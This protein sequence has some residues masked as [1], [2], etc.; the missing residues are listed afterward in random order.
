[1][2]H[3][4]AVRD[5]NQQQKKVLNEMADPPLFAWGLSSV[6]AGSSGSQV[7]AALF[8]KRISSPDE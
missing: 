3:G 6:A 4:H 2:R 7:L 8:P 5:H 1:M